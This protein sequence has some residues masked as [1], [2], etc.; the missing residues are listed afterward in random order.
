[1][2]DITVQEAL[3]TL[4]E[5]ERLVVHMKVLGKM[6]LQE[7]ADALE[8]PMGTIAWRYREAVNKLRRLGYGEG[9]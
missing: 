7:I 5:K 3:E 2:G 8:T 6:T 9:L 1:V 4:N